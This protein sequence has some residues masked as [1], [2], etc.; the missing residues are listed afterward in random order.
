[1]STS[2]AHSGTLAASWTWSTIS[3]TTASTFAASRLRVSARSVRV[4]CDDVRV[5]RRAAGDGADVGRRLVVEAAEPHR[6]DRT[7][8][9]EDRASPGLGAD[10]GMRAAGRG[11]WPR[12]GRRSAR[13]S[14]SR[15]SASR[16]RRRSRRSPRAARQSNA[17]AP[18]RPVSSP[19]VNSSS[20]PT[21]APS[22]AIRRASSSSSATAALLSAPR[23][24]SPAL[25]QPPSTQTGSTRPSWATVSRWAQSSTVG[26]SAER[27]AGDPGKQVAG[28]VGLRRASAPIARS[29]SLSQAVIAAS[30]P[31]TERNPAE[32]GERLVQPPA[33]DF[34]RWTHPT[35]ADAPAP[36]L[37]ARTRRLWRRR[38][39][40]NAAPTKSRNSGAGRS[41]RDLNSG[42][43]C[44]ATK[45]GWSCELDDLDQALVR[46]GA[47]GDQ[48]GR[49]ELRR[50]A[51]VDLVAMT[52]A[53]VD[54]APRRRAR[55]RGC[56]RGA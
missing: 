15:R 41:G 17:L 10:A 1:M 52:V 27:G 31:V 51:Q 9:G 37:R 13:R 26:P 48:T 29:S 39:R 47:G 12:S 30:S 21:G 54:D 33:L 35:P 38:A 22:I 23:I 11:S 34:R 56:R 53:L 46:R 18:A 42:W 36:R 50:A 45:N 43:N 20:T 40:S 25:T 8:R 5:A 6:G 4:L 16:G 32:R 24:V 49:L 2:Q 3:A 19:V 28:R 55:G 44:E 14:R 7:R